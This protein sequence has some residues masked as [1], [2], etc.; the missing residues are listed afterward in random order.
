MMLRR[1]VLLTAILASVSATAVSLVTL[2]QLL[3]R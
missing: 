2:I 3:A 1:M